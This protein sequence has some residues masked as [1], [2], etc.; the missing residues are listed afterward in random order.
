MDASY[1]AHVAERILAAI[2]DLEPRYAAEPENQQINAGHSAVCL[3]S[4][5]GQVWGQVFGTDKLRQRASFS[6]AY[7]KCSQVWITGYPTGTYEELV[8]AKKIDMW[9]YGIHKP[10]F[11]GWEGGQS[12]A[13]DGATTLSAGYSGFRGDHDLEIVSL[14]VAAVTQTR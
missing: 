3:M 8:Y 7:R 6:L 1:L 13:I 5:D 12:I 2:R 4:A 10:D 14:A 11:V 9:K